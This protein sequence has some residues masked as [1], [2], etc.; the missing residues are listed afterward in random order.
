ML[1]LSRLKIVTGWFLLLAAI[2]AV[3]W[4]CAAGVPAR[5]VAS[6]DDSALQTGDEPRS[7]ARTSRTTS[8]PA[9][10]REAEFVFRGAAKGSKTVSLVV[11]GTSAPV[12]C[13]PVKEDLRILVG[14]RRVGIDGLRAGTRVAIRLDAAN[15]VIQDIRVLERP[16]RMPIL[17]SAKDVEQLE[18]PS[19]A[20]VLGALS[21]VPRS[22]PGV[23]EV[24]R[25]DI[26]VVRERL[27]RQVH[28]PR[29]YPLVGPAEHHHY[30]WKC[31][32]FY[33]ETVE[34]GYPYPARIQRPH[35]EVVY[36]DKDF[37]VLAR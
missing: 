31:T 12:L 8:R 7:P 13:L 29:F 20:E 23:L 3:G 10:D 15:S 17:A 26:Q 18:Q 1:L 24:S 6:G 4:T 28:P 34:I 5:A 19:D 16:E 30:E 2:V 21:Q 36:I 25:D 11:A 33:R 22:V 9:E 27:T 37:L 32:V 35:V 14:G